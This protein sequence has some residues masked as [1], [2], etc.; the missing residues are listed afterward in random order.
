MLEDGQQTN[1]MNPSCAAVTA[2]D[3][4][5]FVDEGMENPFL[6]EKHIAKAL[7]QRVSPR[8]REKHASAARIG[9]PLWEIQVRNKVAAFINQVIP[10]LAA[11]AAAAL[12]DLEDS[13]VPEQA[14]PSCANK[15]D[16]EQ[17][18]EVDNLSPGAAIQD[19]SSGNNNHEDHGC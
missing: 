13:Q 15:E 8:S 9:N 11:V 6:L 10:R 5:E 2:A 14:N 18:H 12:V 7:C 16:L 1:Q 19:H 3:Q 4:E 17:S